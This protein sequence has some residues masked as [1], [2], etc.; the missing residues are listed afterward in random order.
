V[1]LGTNDSAGGALTYTGSVTA[2]GGAGMLDGG[3]GLLTLIG[4]APDVTGGSFN[5]SLVST[6]PSGFIAESSLSNSNY[7]P[8]GGGGGGGGGGAGEVGIDVPEPG[9][10]CLIVIGGAGILARR[11]RRN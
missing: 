1:F 6:N 7:E 10:V 3:D 4:V 11:R 5:G 9:S 2:L 8:L